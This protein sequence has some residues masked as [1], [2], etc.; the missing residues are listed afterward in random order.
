MLLGLFL[1]LV[2]SF[3][4]AV[5]I[6]ENSQITLL[7]VSELQDGS[8]VG[9][10]AYLT[11]QIRE[12]SGSVFLDSYPA[13]R[14]DT[15]VSARMANEIAC[16]YS[17][18]DCSKYDFFY[19]IQAGA[20]S[21]GGPSAGSA[22]TILTLSSLLDQPLKNNL[23][24]TGAI[25][26]GG[27]IMPVDGIKEKVLAAENENYDLVLVPRLAFS[28]EN[29]KDF[30][31]VSNDNSKLYRSD[32]ENFSIEINEV[33][34]L[35]EAFKIATVNSYDFSDSP[36]INVPQEY[37]K[38][39][40]ETADMLCLRS[41]EL[42]NKTTNFNESQLSIANDFLNSSIIAEN[43][44]QN[45]PR[46]SFCYSA[47][48]NLRGLLLSNFT[49]DLLLE[50][51]QRLNESE[52]SFEKDIDSYELKT[53][54]DLETY[55]IV[56]ERLLESKN[57]ISNIN[58]SNISSQVLAQAI[59]R[60]YSGVV[61]SGFFGMKGDELK[62][63]DAS[64]KQACEKELQSVHTRNNYLQ[65]FMPAY[66]LQDLF[67]EIDGVNNYIQSQDYALCLFKA[68]KAKSYADFL[69]TSAT[70]NNETLVDLVNEKQTVALNLISK[71]QDLGVF[72]ILG[73]SYYDYSKALEEDS[74]YSSL[75]FAENSI[76]FSDLS[77]Y[78]EK[79]Q[80]SFSSKVVISLTNI[81]FF[82]S[83]LFFG[84]FLGLMLFRRKKQL[85]TH[86]KKKR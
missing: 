39:M 37:A 60:Y 58:E 50:N 2:S 76:A 55:S 53:F 13:T 48:V 75:M 3:T 40:K 14:I 46:A 16:D 69:I 25:S 61:W 35:A 42:L 17:G 71:Q 27:I 34:N 47:N 7:S 24:A 33:T 81:L 86:K 43:N 49:Q 70:L 77:D 54:S 68:S 82:S 12:G 15:Q 6:G 21:I 72:P 57:L 85:K 59:E 11:L 83:G 4:S 31:N 26:S 20:S 18:I 8:L 62:L 41:L 74:Y 30:F 51:L 52:I 1:L 36:E 73:Y 44:S 63:N 19:T 22:I 28:N 9:S 45:Y 78:F 29:D 38:R 23:A 67:S 10:L 32:F 5:Q 56:K 84:L 79:S 64:L 66:F 80:T 65:T